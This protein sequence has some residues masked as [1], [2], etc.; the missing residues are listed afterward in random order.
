MNRCCPLQVHAVVRA[1][2]PNL[3]EADDQAHHVRA[4]CACR[5]DSSSVSFS[6]QTTYSSE[7]RQ[8]D[9]GSTRLCSELISEDDLCCVRIPVHSH[10]RCR[11]LPCAMDVTFLGANLS[12]I[13]LSAPCRI[14]ASLHLREN[15]EDRQG[16]V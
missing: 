9:C 8:A 12:V 14:E 2:W 4:R 7:Q 6:D 5:A 16:G 1:I 13:L 15:A 3:C 10:V 11:C